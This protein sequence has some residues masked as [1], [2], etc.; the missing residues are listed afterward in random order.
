MGYFLQSY[1]SLTD[2]YLIFGTEL[3]I[4]RS[5]FYIQ[6]NRDFFDIDRKFKTERHVPGDRKKYRYEMFG[7][8]GVKKKPYSYFI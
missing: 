5:L 2:L 8:F 7:L 1:T 6:V 3:V 4:L